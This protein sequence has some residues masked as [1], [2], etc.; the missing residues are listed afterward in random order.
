DGSERMRYTPERSLRSRTHSANLPSGP[1][2]DR[3]S[4]SSPGTRIMPSPTSLG[5]DSRDGVCAERDA[6]DDAHPLDRSDRGIDALLDVLGHIFGCSRDIP[7]HVVR[8]T[9]EL[10]GGLPELLE[11]EKR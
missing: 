9:W 3:H 7:G 6:S 8:A 5:H 10:D 2:T 1:S 4:S 11:E